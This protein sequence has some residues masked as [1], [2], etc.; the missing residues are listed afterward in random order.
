MTRQGTWLLLVAL[1]WYLAAM[2]RTLALTILLLSELGLLVVMALLS[3]YFRATLNASFPSETAF[4]EKERDCPCR[5]RLEAQGRLPVGRPRLTL[6]LSYRTQ[7]RKTTQRFY[8][9]AEPGKETEVTFYVRPPYCGPLYIELRQ[10][11]TWDYL[12]LFPSK[13]RKR[14]RTTLAVLPPPREL[15]IESR[16]LSEL[17]PGQ[18]WNAAPTP[19]EGISPEARDLREYR[20]GDSAR[21]IHWKLSARTD[22]LWT[23]DYEDEQEECFTLFADLS[24]SR[25][26]RPEHWDAF[27]ETL[28]AI[29]LGLRRYRNAVRVFWRDAD[30]DLQWDVTDWKSRQ[31][32]FL[33]LYLSDP[34][35]GNSERPLTDFAFNTELLWTRGAETVWKFDA[36]DALREIVENTFVV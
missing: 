32:F 2:F 9:G 25:K 24:E 29:I 7:C 16:T 11:L 33:R 6:A 28:S 4:G 13:R 8:G 23:R 30:K 1:T 5:I 36:A 27:Y 21:S 26:M 3:V 18:T 14:E 15:R 31:T 20:P 22:Q 12:F 35:E 19:S 17:S 10:I 34:P